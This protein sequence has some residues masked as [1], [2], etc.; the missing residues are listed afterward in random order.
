MEI[1]FREMEFGIFLS[2]TTK[3]GTSGVFCKDFGEKIKAAIKDT[4]SADKN[5]RFFIKKSGFQILNI[6]SL[7]ARDVLVV[8]AKQQVGLI[9]V[10]NSLLSATNMGNSYIA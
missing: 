1:D 10:G 7:G 4:S 2:E 3:R 8:P 6:P 9:M 5:L